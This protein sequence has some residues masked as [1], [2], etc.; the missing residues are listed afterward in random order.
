[1]D[2][3]IQISDATKRNWEKLKVTDEEIEKK[4]SK[5][6][7]KLYSKKHI[8]PSE[9][10]ENKLNQKVVKKLLDLIAENQLSTENS[11]YN[12]GVN[13]LAKNGLVTIAD[14]EIISDNQYIRKILG[15]VG[16]KD[17]VLN[18][19]LLNFE[20]P[21]DEID[22]L[23]IIYQSMMSEGNKNKK[24]SYYTPPKMIK[25][26]KNLV[27]SDTVL[28]D[29]CCG[30][31]SFLLNLGD[32]IK[33]PDNIFGADLDSIACF[34]SKINLIVRYK[35]IKFEPQI[36]NLDFLDD[37][38]LE[39]FKKKRINLIA[40]NPPWGTKYGKDYTKNFS[41]I[42]SK[43]ICSYFIVQA[44]KILSKDGICCMVLPEAILNV[45]IH[46]DIRKFILGNYGIEEIKLWGK[47]FKGVLSDV[48]SLKLTKNYDE[49]IRIV[50]K[51][52][53]KTINK[54]EYFKNK[55]YVF[56][57]SDNLYS[58]IIDYIFGRPYETL[59]NSIWGLGIVTGNNEKHIRPKF[60][61]GEKIYKGKNI[62]SYLIKDTD[63][64]IE[65]KRENF[66]QT[67]SDEIY[68]AK[69]KLVYKFISKKLVFAY[70]DKQRLFLNS[71]NILIPEMETHSAKTVLAFLNSKVFNFIYKYKFNALKVLKGNLI[72]LPFPKLT[73]NY[74]NIIEN[75]VENYLENGDN[76][77][78]EDIENTVFETFNLPEKYVKIIKNNI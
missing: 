28:L 44:E 43:E 59:E 67:A 78:L 29:P 69:E 63:D 62:T 56:N 17:S 31:G 60:K 24:G 25:Y 39:K 76:L 68:R 16:I 47:V 37:E 57:I 22:I 35:N 58:E 41:E 15:G 9:Y 45:G 66:Q 61:G 42:L 6:A 46:Q 73:E 33:N 34:I 53:I 72:Q 11:I 70:D 51:H 75:Y 40:T 12:L 50:G 2:N 48:I 32:K 3:I 54:S 71:A 77:V 36:Y 49:K 10:F 8:I 19:D 18:K 20:L 14:N 21:D 27:S 7:N 13:Y 38:I 5:R 4:L 23:G 30:T 52:S 1:M 26:F 74:K 65:Y 64:Y 55:N